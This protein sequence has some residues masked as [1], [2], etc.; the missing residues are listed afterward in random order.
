MS[1]HKPVLLNE[2]ME[3]LAPQ[4]GENF[5]DGT[6]GGGGHS[7]AILE[8]IAPNGR[9]LAVDW[10]KEAIVKCP[11]NKRIECAQG[12]F[13]N[14]KTIMQQTNFPSANGLLLDLGISS[15]ELE[16]SGRGFSFQKNE[17]LLMT[18]N[19]E[20]VPVMQLLRE[21]STDDLTNILRKYGEE[22]HA[23]QIATAIKQR[24]R[25]TPIKTTG[26]LVEVITKVTRRGAGRLHPATRTFMALRIYANHELENIEKILQDSKNILSS[27]GRV[28]IISFHSL[29]DRL[30]KNYFRQFKKDDLGQILTKKPVIPTREETHNNPRA[31]SA[32]LRIFKYDAH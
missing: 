13:A 21:L 25:L 3:L 32:K 7:Q 9:L 4:P 6:F 17:P 16:S 23:S 19:D 28:A 14:L 20:Q 5:I 2:V 29:E 15:D 31:R 22:R 11:V 8:K 30:V 18:Y 24:N 12:N 26:E 27:G 1:I 10:N